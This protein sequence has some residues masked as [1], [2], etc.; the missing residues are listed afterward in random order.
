M[1]SLGGLT[2]SMVVTKNMPWVL[3]VCRMYMMI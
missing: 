2:L 1:C 3:Y